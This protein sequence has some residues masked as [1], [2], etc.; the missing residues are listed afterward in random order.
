[1]L[2]IIGRSQYARKPYEIIDR[3]LNRADAEF[4]RAEYQLSF[5]PDWKIDVKESKRQGYIDQ[6]AAM[7]AEGMTA[8]QIEDVTGINRFAVDKIGKTLVDA[9]LAVKRGPGTPQSKDSKEIDDLI[10][11]L[12]RAD[13]GMKAIATALDMQYFTVRGRVQKLNKQG[14]LP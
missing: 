4:L 6:V 14:R 1:M 9:G 12:R 10:V 7:R 13:I 3:T 2:K 8:G 11:E 5:G